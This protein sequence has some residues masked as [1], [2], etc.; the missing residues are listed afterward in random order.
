MNR[1]RTLLETHQLQAGY[2]SRRARPAIIA[3]PLS[4]TIREG[5]LICLLG[6]NGSE[7]PPC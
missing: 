4:I 7:N 5:Q 6:P 3:G 1:R 2:G